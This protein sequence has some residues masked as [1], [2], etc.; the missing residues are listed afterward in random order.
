M[1]QKGQTPYLKKALDDSENPPYLA[2]GATPATDE[3]ENNWIIDK[4]LGDETGPRRSVLVRLRQ[5]ETVV[6]QIRVE[7]TIASTKMTLI[8]KTLG[9]GVENK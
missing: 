2:K 6:R 5:L 1:T 3:Q 8:E 7:Q 4:Q 9:V